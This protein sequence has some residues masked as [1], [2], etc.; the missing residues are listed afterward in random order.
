MRVR[1]A[2]FDPDPEYTENEGTPLVKAQ[3]P[4]P[5]EVAQ[6]PKGNHYIRRRLSASAFTVVFILAA[7]AGLSMIV[8]ASIESSSIASPTTVYEKTTVALGNIQKFTAQHVSLTQDP[9]TDEVYIPLTIYSSSRGCSS[10]PTQNSKPDPVTNVSVQLQPQTVI[11]RGY[12]MPESVLNYTICTVTNQL[13][14]TNYHIDL[15]VAEDLDENLHFDPDTYPNTLHRDI[16][17]TY[18]RDL[19]PNNQCYSTITHTI[20]KRGPYSIVLFAPSRVEV[21]SSNI[22]FWYSQNNHIK[23]I[24]TSYLHEKCSINNRSEVCKISVGSLHHYISVFV[25]WSK[26]VTATMIGLRVSIHH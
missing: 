18:D 16:A 26:L 25:W 22:S 24:D 17:L 5:T 7:G 9:G 23:V 15:Y 12:L 21:P 13:N 11:F 2:R 14:G 19:Q 6:R 10:L 3:H 4:A 8:L 1:L 20:T